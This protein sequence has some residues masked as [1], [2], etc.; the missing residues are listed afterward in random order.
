MWMGIFIDGAGIAFWGKCQFK[1]GYVWGLRNQGRFNGK[2]ILP[3][4]MVKDIMKGGSQ[5][6]FGKS[7]YGTL[8]NWL[9]KYVDYT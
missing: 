5:E 3:A 9:Q 7:A 8:K 4:A 2:Q 6:A 1:I